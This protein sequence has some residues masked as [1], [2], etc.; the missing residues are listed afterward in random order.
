MRVELE[1]L[2]AA[3][4]GYLALLFLVAYATERGFI[5][6]RIARHP[7]VSTLA[8][9]VYAS[10][11]SFNGAVGFAKLEGYRFLAIYLGVTLSCLL[12][13]LIWRPV[14]QLT[15]EYQLASLADLFVF[16]YGGPWVGALVTLFMLAGSV[17]YLALEIRAITES[18]SVLAHGASPIVIGLG[19]C[20]T[21]TLF[22]ILFGA[23]HPAQR[24]RHEGLVVA[25]AF[26]SLVKLLAL[27]SIGAF[28]VFGVFDGFS[29]MNA[30]LEQHP[31]ALDALYTPMHGEPWGVL[32]FLAFAAA[33][34]LPRQF[35]VAFA[36]SPGAR[37]LDTSSWGLPAY[38]LLLSLPIAPILW[39]GTV[40]K[41]DANP[42][43]YVLGITLAGRSNL[44]PL[45]AFV[46]GISA[47]GG[48]VILTTLALASMS[49]NHLL[50][51]LRPPQRAR[52]LYS[53]LLWARRGL[54]LAII[55]SGFGFFLLLD[56]RLGLAEL[57]LI[58]FAA[59]AQFLPGL[60]GVLFWRRATRAGFIAGLLGGIAVWASLL[61][62]PLLFR[63][64]TPAPSFHERL[65]MLPGDPWSLPVLLSLAINAL[66]FV[67]SSTLFPEPESPERA[68]QPADA[69]PQVLSATSPSEFR[70]R[71]VSVLGRDAAEAEV[72]R[73]LGD[74]TM[75]RGERRPA[76]LLLLRDRIERNL[77]GLMGPM[78][79]KMVVSESLR[80]DV[81]SRTALAEQLRLL[82]QRLR[83]ARVPL[84]GAAAELEAFRRYF[85]QILEG[86][87]Q[88]VCALGPDSDIVI[89][90]RALAALTGVQAETAVG[91]R[92][93]EL[94]APWG[95]LLGGFAGQ[96]QESRRESRV[97]LG[98]QERYLKLY[99]SELDSAD[100]PLHPTSIL[101]GAQVILVDDL[102]ES[103]VLQAQ[104]AH[105]D[106]LASV[107]RLAAGVAHEIGNPLTGI[108][109]VAQNLPFDMDPAVVEERAELIVEQ[110]RRI[111]R[112]VRT[113]VTFSH[114]GSD[115][116]ALE[117]PGK[118]E[119][120][121]LY[122]AVEE[123]MSLVR[124]SRKA[125]GI[126]CSNQCE[127]GVCLTGD[128]HKL[129]QVFVNLLANACDASVAGSKVLVSSRPNGQSVY[130]DVT[131]F[132][133]GIPEDIRDRIFDPFFTTKPPGE[134]TGLGLS[135][136]YSIVRE[137]R[138]SLDVT[139]TPGAGTT[140]TL[141]L[142]RA[143]S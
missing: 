132:G 116:L 72:Q 126:E 139:S 88:G 122:A 51:P 44:L 31:A 19:F 129:I 70:S 121:E 38:L 79:A 9:G 105:Q 118:S 52:D 69:G 104:L 120:F 25:I 45:L 124:L 113:L 7:L 85:R 12:I 14:L 136:V 34:L 65:Q 30:W 102:T 101:G 96:Q 15:R 11:W 82:E 135:L 114:A 143:S 137:H 64:D 36:E 18:V 17:P 86:L 100:V 20:A 95:E 61:A 93:T 39:A 140:F 48:A 115:A 2:A 4:V 127:A 58:S 75:A 141:T 62:F 110:T 123:A 50:L 78:L 56:K 94:P 142:P 13:P 5:P 84:E 53:W 57:G 112:I 80:M 107:G 40:F 46:G 54:I 73:A 71:L 55:L 1:L 98:S 27:L 37:A 91:L 28:A 6:A 3:G 24:D 67:G 16:R 99:R 23:R 130:V 133:S 33:F 90:N 103:K 134:G 63:A 119:A 47:A 60:V 35:H 109:C 83:E 125:R 92:I 89:W 111:D 74:L 138:G 68:A 128:R 131:D 29:G 66:L 10:S 43:Y 81:R 87:P 59:V 49:L 32:L 108:A 21:L 77:S 41:P 26:E 97:R 8:L 106:R 117:S 22:A 76:E 42:E